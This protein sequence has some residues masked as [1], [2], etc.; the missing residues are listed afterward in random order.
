MIALPRKTK[1]MLASL[2]IAWTT[3]VGYCIAHELAT[4]NNHPAPN[5]KQASWCK[6]SETVADET[7]RSRT[8][9]TEYTCPPPKTLRAE[10]HTETLTPTGW[11]KTTP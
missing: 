3:L 2:F 7:A 10:T 6:P 9:K 11:Q 4:I 1:L 5:A 8:V